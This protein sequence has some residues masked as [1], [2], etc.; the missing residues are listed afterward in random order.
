VAP[1]ILGNL[2]TLAL[3][4]F[5][6]SG[7]C[8]RLVYGRDWR[9]VYLYWNSLCHIPDYSNHH[10]CHRENFK[11]CSILGSFAKLRKATISFVIYVRLS[12][13]PS[14]WN[15]SA[16]TGR[17]FTKFYISGFFENLSK[18]YSFIQSDKNKGHFT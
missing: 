6:V 9:L 10:T 5:K 3:S 2:W 13:R 1:R 7:T 11:S 15:N 12:V 14:A 16:P 8:T 4:I 17:I 18:I